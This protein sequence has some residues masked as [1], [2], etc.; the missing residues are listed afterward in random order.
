M[1]NSMQ[2][3]NKEFELIKAYRVHKD[4]QGA[5]DRLLDLDGAAPTERDKNKHTYFGIRTKDDRFLISNATL[6]VQCH[7]KNALELINDLFNRGFEWCEDAILEKGEKQDTF[8]SL[9]GSMYARLQA[10]LNYTNNAFVILDALS[11]DEYRLLDVRTRSSIAVAKELFGCF[12]N[13]E[14]KETEA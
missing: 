12:N 5:V 2:V 9:Y 11:S 3:T 7:L 14:K 13:T 10:V 6:D 4:L 8:L 1:E